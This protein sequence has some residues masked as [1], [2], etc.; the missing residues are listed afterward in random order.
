M[1]ALWQQIAAVFAAVGL[2]QIDALAVVQRSKE[3]GA[4]LEQVPGR[5]ERRSNSEEEQEQGRA[6]QQ[7]PLPTPG[8]SFKV[9]RRV[10]WRLIFLLFE[11]AQG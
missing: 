4:V 2:N 5:D 1:E 6:S 3:S 11:G 7:V 8:G 9:H 10:V